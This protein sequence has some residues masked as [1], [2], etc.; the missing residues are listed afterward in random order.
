MRG[1]PKDD[2]KAISGA[3]VDDHEHDDDYD[4]GC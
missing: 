1:A 4:G 2:H 3:S